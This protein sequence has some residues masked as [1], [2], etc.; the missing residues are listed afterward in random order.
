MSLWEHIQQTDKENCRK[1]G[2]EFELQNWTFLSIEERKKLVLKLMSF[3]SE[4]LE[5]KKAPEISYKQLAPNNPG[6]YDY[7]RKEIN[8]NHDSLNFGILTAVTVAHE[9]RHHYQYEKTEDVSKV[10]WLNKLRNLFFKNPVESRI[11]Y[12]L[13]NPKL[14][15]VEEW[16]S[17]FANYIRGETKTPNPNET[18]EDI[19]IGDELEEYKNQPIEEDAFRYEGIFMKQFFID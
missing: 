16:D 7:V 13:A 8:I 12:W 2:K 11:S 3:L 4:R 6:N 1:I 10:N 19:V 17:N 14:E 9:L 5:I 15:P 18:L